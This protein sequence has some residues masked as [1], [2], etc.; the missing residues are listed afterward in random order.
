MQEGAMQL[1]I[2]DGQVVEK[3]A[4]GVTLGQRSS[5]WAD[6][7]SHPET[8]IPCPASMVG[9]PIQ[10]LSWDGA[11]VNAVLP[12][13]SPRATAWAVATFIQAQSNPPAALAA[14]AN[15]ILAILAAG[16]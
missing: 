16:G 4:D 13:I 10:Y 15:L 11:E 5:S 7:K 2:R 14:E 1:V 9:I 6:G 3:V 12:R 8:L